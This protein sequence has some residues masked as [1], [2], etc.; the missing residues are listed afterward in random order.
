MADDPKLAEFRDKNIELMK[1]L[2]DLKKRF[3]GI[4]PDAVEADRAKLAEFEKAKPN[5]RITELETLLAAEKASRLDIQKRADASVIETQVTD[6]FLKSG[7]R[8]EARAFIVGQA[9]GVFTLENGKLISTKHSPDRPG[10]RMSLSEWLSLQTREH[11]FCFFP[12][13]GGGADPK[14]G[15]GSSARELRNPT[16]QQLGEHATAIAKGDLKVVY[17]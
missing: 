10:E 9:A 2:D 12:S 17:D 8:P 16:P 7:G 3:E 1:E 11:A 6:G 13:A 5:E 14:R 15:G 4:D